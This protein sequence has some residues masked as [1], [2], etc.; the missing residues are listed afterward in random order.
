VAAPSSGPL[1]ADGLGLKRAVELAAS[2]AGS[3]EDY[4][5]RLEVVAFDDRGD[6]EQAARLARDISADPAVIAVVGHLTSGCS[7]AAAQVYAEAGLA[8]LTPSAT[9]P[10]VTLQQTRTGW[11]GPRV[12]FRIPPSDAVLGG[13]AAQYAY[14]RLKLRRIA[15]IHDDTPYGRDLSEA[16]SRGFST[17]G[18]Q[19]LPGAPAGWPGLRPD[20]AFYGGAYKGFGL[21]LKQARAA[22]WRFPFISGDGAKAPELFDIAGPAA[23]GAYLAASGVPLE[24]LPSASDFAA[25]YLQRYA[26]APRTFD[27]YAYEAGRI[28][29]E[30]LR[31]SG[32]DRA[33]LLEALRASRHSGMLG[34]IVFDSKG[35]TLKSLATM[36]QADAAKKTF[37][38]LY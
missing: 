28:L 29:V 15:V 26:A 10:E 23:D 21:L 1:A 32:P 2:E 3:C 34:T 12:A 35:D 22:G 13:Y 27:H 18:G 25:R 20:G 5:L 33:E 4:P 19:A 9:S 30:C 17:Q 8:M 6:P 37:V 36:T 31:Q 11:S 16:F 38:P 14:G 7:I 24:S